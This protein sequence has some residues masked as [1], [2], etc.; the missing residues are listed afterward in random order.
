YPRKTDSGYE[1]DAPA[2]ASPSSPSRFPI[3]AR[4]ASECMSQTREIRIPARRP[5]EWVR[6]LTAHKL[7][8]D[9]LIASFL[10]LALSV[11]GVDH[12]AD[13][14][15]QFVVMIDPTTTGALGPE[16]GSCGTGLFQSAGTPALELI[17]SGLRWVS[18]RSDDDVNVIRAGVDG[19]QMPI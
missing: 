11:L 10:P 13:G 12:V 16:S 18:G 6:L 2:S 1:P 15:L 5:S 14:G 17:P 9:F 7:P 4:R 19:V 8:S 3:R